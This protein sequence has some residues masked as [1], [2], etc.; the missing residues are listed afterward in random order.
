MKISNDDQYITIIF[1]NKLLVIVNIQQGICSKELA[2][3]NLLCLMNINKNENGNPKN[4]GDDEKMEAG[5]G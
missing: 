1:D 2:F 3:N 5:L 4:Y